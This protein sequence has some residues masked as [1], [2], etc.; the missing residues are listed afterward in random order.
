MF[1]CSAPVG[2]LDFSSGS[3]GVYASGT[4]PCDREARCARGAKHHRCAGAMPAE[5]GYASWR[6]GMSLL[7]VAMCARR[8]GSVAPESHRR[9]GIFSRQTG[10]NVH[11]AIPEW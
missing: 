11:V 10:L 3:S 7:P 9:V 8:G 2:V 5:R 1:R 6:H 4:R